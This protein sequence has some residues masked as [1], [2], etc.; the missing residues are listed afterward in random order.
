MLALSDGVG[1]GDGDGVGV[2]VGVGV[3]VTVP[4]VGIVRLLVNSAVVNAVRAIPTTINAAIVAEP[5]CIFI[6]NPPI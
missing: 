2:A 3:G 1:V 4:F 6:L 5:F